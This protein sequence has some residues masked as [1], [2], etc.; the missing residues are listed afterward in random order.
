MLARPATYLQPLFIVDQGHG[1]VLPSARDLDVC[2]PGVTSPAAFEPHVTAPF[3]SCFGCTPPV[4]PLL[5]CFRSLYM[6]SAEPTRGMIMLSQTHTR[7]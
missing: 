3:I 6:Q 1:R 5:Q 2:V 4:G 7:K